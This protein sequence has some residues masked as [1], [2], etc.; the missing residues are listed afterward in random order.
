MF[1]DS[2][3]GKVGDIQTG[4][5]VF[6]NDNWNGRQKNV[7]GIVSKVN[8]FPSGAVSLLLR[9]GQDFFGEGSISARIE[10]GL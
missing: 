5:K 2:I 8:K 10:R 4:D 1:G 9:N 6:I 3:S 7:E